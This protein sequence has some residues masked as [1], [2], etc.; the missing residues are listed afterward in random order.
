MQLGNGMWETAEYNNRQQITEIGLGHVDNAQ[1][2]LK[3]E[4]KYDSGP[5]SDDNNG[6]MLEQ[7]ITVPAASG[8]PG[9]TATQ[10]YV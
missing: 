3:L 6:S 1:D 5:N 2:L 10:T 9:F 4:F 8:T 7:K